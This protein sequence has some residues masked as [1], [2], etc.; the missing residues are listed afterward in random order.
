MRKWWRRLDTTQLGL[1]RATGILSVLFISELLL[2]TAGHLAEIYVMGRLGPEYLSA[3]TLSI[4]VLALIFS[5]FVELGT[6][7][8]AMVAQAAGARDDRAAAQAIGQAIVVCAAASLP[9]SAAGVTFA[10]VMLQL[11]GAAGPV[12]AIGTGYTQIGL[13][14]MFVLV[15]PFVLTGALRALG[16]A[17]LATGLQIMQLSIY[18]VLMPVLVLGVGPAPSMGPNGSILALVVARLATAAVQIGFLSRSTASV[19]LSWASLRPHLLA[20]RR[21]LALTWPAAGQQ[22]A[23]YGADV[24]IV[25]L[26][27][28]YGP[29]ATAAF[30]IALR[31]V[32]GLETIAQGIGNATFTVVGQNLGAGEE[33]RA[34]HGTSLATRYG[35]FAVGAGIVLV[36]GLAPAMV[37]FFSPD[38]QVQALGTVAVR[39]LAVSGVFY[40]IALVLTRSFHGAGNTLTP[41]VV[42]LAAL[43]LVQWPVAVGLS[44]PLG[45]GVVGIWAAVAV[46]N[47]TRALVLGVWF[48]RRRGRAV[49]R[50][51]L[52]QTR[53]LADK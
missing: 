15:L 13:A 18:L 45:W 14:T 25:R 22:Y 24:I 16:H 8:A 40:F 4:V 30:S 37:R 49:D 17:A 23:R 10:P 42:D 39:V 19:H 53:A 46:A 11:V 43:W 20:M 33:R 27:A 44:Q 35:L 28:A 52:A 2:N 26:I 31:L 50:L 47:A 38:A 1:G 5:F 21:L 41:M 9:V 12:L 36:A 34:E 48:W 7:L 29:V 3:V 32:E 6:G 51:A